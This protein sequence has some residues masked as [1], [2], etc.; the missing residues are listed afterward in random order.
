M[1]DLTLPPSREL[2]RG[3]LEARRAHLLR[4]LPTSPRHRRRRAALV[5]VPA[6][7]LLLGATAW[8]AQRLTREVTHFESIGC[9]DRVSLEANVTVLNPHAE[10][11]VAVCARLWREGV[12]TGT[13]GT[14]ALQPCVLPTGAVAVFP[15]ADACARLRLAAP[16]ADDLNTLRARTG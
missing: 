6:L 3:R 16:T 5:A 13:P 12:V 7:A 8:T 11:P 9:F 14:P 1:N 4:E 2:P 15:A 10:D